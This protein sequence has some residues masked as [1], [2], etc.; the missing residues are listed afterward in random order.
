ME[1][2]VYLFNDRTFALITINVLIDELKAVF[3]EEF[4]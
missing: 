3:R 1:L 4:Q 2:F